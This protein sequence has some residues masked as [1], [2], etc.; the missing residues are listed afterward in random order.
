M[1]PILEITTPEHTLYHVSP[2]LFNFP[3]RVEISRAREWSPWHPNGVLGVWCSTFPVMCRGFGSNVYRVGLSPDARRVGL[4]FEQ[5]QKLTSPM[6]E[7]DPLIEYLSQ[8]GDVMYLA[9]A[10]EDI[11]E[12]IVVNLDAITSWENVTEEKLTD[13]RY[14]LSITEK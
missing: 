13:I 7:F 2:K 14:P 6:L 11:G 12:V 3:S 1:I 5:F 10:S 8:C 4:P 9:D